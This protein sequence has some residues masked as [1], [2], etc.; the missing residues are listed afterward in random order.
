LPHQP[1][2]LN[3][4]YVIWTSEVMFSRIREEHRSRKV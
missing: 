1:T 4:Y 3:V 2:N